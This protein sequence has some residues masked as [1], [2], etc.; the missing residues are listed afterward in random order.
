MKKSAFFKAFVLLVVLASA[1]AMS[2]QQASFDPYDIVGKTAASDTNAFSGF[3]NPAASGLLNREY[4]NFTTFLAM[5]SF[6]FESINLLG[7]SVTSLGSST[8]VWFNPNAENTELYYR[9]NSA[10]SYSWLS[11]GFGYEAMYD[12]GGKTFG[13]HVL[14]A[15]ISARPFQYLSLG[16]YGSYDFADAWQVAVDGGVRPLGTNLLTLF[17]KYTF[18]QGEGVDYS[19]WSVGASLRPVGGVEIFGSYASGNSVSLGLTLRSSQTSL[20][21]SL[22]MPSTLDAV[23]N[24]TI[25]YALENSPKNDTIVLEKNTTWVEVNLKGSLTA[26]SYFGNTYAPVLQ[27]LGPI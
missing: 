1:A 17:G 3:A 15:G 12:F 20:S 10:S 21:G 22:T 11:M 19:S 8:S 25:A 24:Y 4:F 9:F 2:A 27:V 5:P 16:T 6:S 26:S 7:F 14:M 18:G 13:N 23:S